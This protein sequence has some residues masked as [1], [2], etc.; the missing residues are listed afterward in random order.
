MDEWI[1]LRKLDDGELFELRKQ[2]VHLKQTGCSGKE[3]E[4]IVH[5]RA[6]RISEIWRKFQGGGTEGLRPARP[7]RKEGQKTIL[8]LPRQLEIRRALIENTPDQ[9]KMPYSL[10]TRQIASDFIKREYGVRL[11]PR[12]M[13]NYLKRWHFICNTPM[14]PAQ[15]GRSAEFERFMEEGFPAIVRRAVSENVGIYWFCETLVDKDPCL[16]VGPGPHGGGDP[17]R[18]RMV[19]AVTARGTA[20][21]TFFEGRM[22]QSK[23][24]TLMS[25][26]IRFADRKVFFIAADT[27]A[28]RGEKTLA[29]LKDHENRIELFFYPNCT[30]NRFSGLLR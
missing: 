11:S 29:W 20:R 5:I 27:E 4:Q 13:T 2:V 16:D 15:A 21:F 6:N 23:A 18:V 3:I 7:G 12:C 30:I 19:A 1:D 28:F 14:K 9:L 26:L 8:P 24:V 17:P 25:R 22:S 10:W